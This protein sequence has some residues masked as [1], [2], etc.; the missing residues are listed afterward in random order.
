MHIEKP[1]FNKPAVEMVKITN[2]FTSAYKNLKRRALKNPNMRPPE[3]YQG[4][5][6]EKC[7]VWSNGIIFYISL[8][9]KYPFEGVNCN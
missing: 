1:K 9:G 3:F 7:F 5:F 8:C 2:F 6:T 4:I